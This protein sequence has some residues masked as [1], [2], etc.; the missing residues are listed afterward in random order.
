M[1]GK[2]ECL[3]SDNGP[4]FTPRFMMLWTVLNEIDHSLIY[5]GKP[6]GNSIVESVN[7]KC[8]DEFLN[9]DLFPSVTDMK[10]LSS[11]EGAL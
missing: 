5:S 3:G 7:G 2:P 9:G 8:R 4:E 10:K 11:R 1:N 6:M